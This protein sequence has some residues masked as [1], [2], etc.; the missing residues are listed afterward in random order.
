M[1]DECVNYRNCVWISLDD[2]RSLTKL[3]LM[4]ETDVIKVCVLRS[5]HTFIR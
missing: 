4:T 1:G 5:V 3:R 2:T